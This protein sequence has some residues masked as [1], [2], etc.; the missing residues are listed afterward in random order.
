MATNI[1]LL[2]AVII[3]IAIW[4]WLFRDGE[5]T[6]RTGRLSSKWRG[7]LPGSQIRIKVTPPPEDSVSAASEQADQRRSTPD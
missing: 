6:V 5:G 1:I 2:L 3:M 4:I 7:E